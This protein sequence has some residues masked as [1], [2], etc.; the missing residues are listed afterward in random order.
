MLSNLELIYLYEIHN[1]MSPYRTNSANQ[2]NDFTDKQS[3]NFL[4]W[5]IL[6]YINLM[7]GI[8]VQLATYWKASSM[9]N[10]PCLR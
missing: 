1:H 8:S 2:I 5:Q 9:N 10:Y 6:G 3:H 4:K 7:V